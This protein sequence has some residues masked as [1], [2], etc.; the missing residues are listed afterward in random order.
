MT[1]LSPQLRKELSDRVKAGLARARLRAQHTAAEQ[2]RRETPLAAPY[3]RCP[4]GRGIDEDGSAYDI[5]CC[6]ACAW[7]ALR[8]RLAARRSRG[9]R[10]EDTV[11]WLAQSRLCPSSQAPLMNQE[12]LVGPSGRFEKWTTASVKAVRQKEQV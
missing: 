3:P 4:H 6:G 5:V 9:L 12:K 11:E 1:D 7:R 2:K 10:Y 8:E